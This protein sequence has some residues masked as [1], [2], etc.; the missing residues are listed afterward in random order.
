MSEKKY[1]VAVNGLMIKNGTIAPF[2]TEVTDG[3]EVENAYQKVIDGFLLSKE[4]FDA[5]D[6]ADKEAIGEV[7]ET[8]KD[9]GDN[10]IADDKKVKNLI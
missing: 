6:K 5:K 10:N 2:G 7:E 9:E 3:K 1:T 8:K 4:D